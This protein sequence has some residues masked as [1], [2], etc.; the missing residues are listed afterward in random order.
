MSD[1]VRSKFQYYQQVKCTPYIR[2]K[3]RKRE[4][5]RGC[6]GLGL[7]NP[8]SRHD[9]NYW[10]LITI[11]SAPDYTPYVS[12]YHTY[13]THSTQY[14]NFLMC[15]YILCEQYCTWLNSI[16]HFFVVLYFHI[17]HLFFSYHALV[18]FM[19]LYFNL[20]W[21]RLCPI[22]IYHWSAPSANCALSCL[23][24]ALQ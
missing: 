10:W 14:Q 11:L 12:T 6:L 1:R 17:L 19:Y 21:S 8:E 15:F 16:L 7:A 2:V 20:I 3:V 4:K 5:N 24:K 23:W 9:S 13:H 22:H 18:H